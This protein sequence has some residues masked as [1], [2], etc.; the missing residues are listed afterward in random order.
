MRLWIHLATGPLL[1]KNHH[2]TILLTLVSVMCEGYRKTCQVATVFL[3]SSW[4]QKNL[5]ECPFKRI[6]GIT[7]TS[8]RCFAR[9]KMGIRM[10]RENP[11]LLH[12]LLDY[13]WCRVTFTTDC[14]RHWFSEIAHNLCIYF[15]WDKYVYDSSVRKSFSPML[16]MDFYQVT[17]GW[18]MSNYKRWSSLLLNHSE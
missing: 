18:F 6:S 7:V 1:E 14:V 17:T 12:S 8:W 5:M 11:L 10:E 2:H 3:F 16:Y 15:Q 9:K 4:R 13:T